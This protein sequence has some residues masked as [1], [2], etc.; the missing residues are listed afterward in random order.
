MD[1]ETIEFI[2]DKINIRGPQMDGNFVISLN[3]GEYEKEKVA[4]LIKIEGN[5]K[6]IIEPE[7]RGIIP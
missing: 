2:A 4:Q 3:V 7:S 5:V 1:E 6:V